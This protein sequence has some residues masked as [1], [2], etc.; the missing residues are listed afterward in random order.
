M[1]VGVGEDGDGGEERGGGGGRKREGMK[2]YGDS[3]GSRILNMKCSE[4]GMMEVMPCLRR[5][6]TGNGTRG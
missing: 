3:E 1:G 5:S 2:G 6:G 4:E